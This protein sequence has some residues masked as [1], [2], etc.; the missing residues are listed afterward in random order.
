[1][2]NGILAYLGQALAAFDPAA[3]FEIY[4]GIF[5]KIIEIS[6]FA[7]EEKRDAIVRPGN[8]QRDV[9]GRQSQQAVAAQGIAEENRIVVRFIDR[10]EHFLK[11]R[12]HA[13]LTDVVQSFGQKLD[14]D[15]IDRSGNRGA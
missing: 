2:L 7:T 11:P 9:F 5:V 13:C 1:M 12:G 10:G 4:A 8:D 6:F 15:L 3:G 14:I